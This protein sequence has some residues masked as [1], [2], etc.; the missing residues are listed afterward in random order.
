MSNVAVSGYSHSAK[1]MRSTP[2]SPGML[3]SLSSSAIFSCA[4]A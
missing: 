2:V 3:T 4:K 1:R